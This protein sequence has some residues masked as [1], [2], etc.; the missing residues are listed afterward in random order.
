MASSANPK[1]SGKAA[2]PTATPTTTNN[3]RLDE[4]EQTIDQQEAQLEAQQE[5]IRIQGAEVERQALLLEQMTVAVQQLQAQANTPASST[6]H[7]TTNERPRTSTKVLPPRRFD[8]T[9]AKLEGFLT[10]MNIYLRFNHTAFPN[11]TDKILAV[12]MQMEGDAGDWMEPMVKDYLD[13]AED[14][15]DCKESTQIVFA[16]YSSF[17]TEIRKIFGE[18]DPSRTAERRLRGLRQAKSAAT[19]TTE[20]KQIQNRIEWDNDA[21]NSCYY[22]GLKDRVKDEISRGERPELLEDM[23]ALALRIDNRQFEREMEKKRQTPF[24]PFEHRRKAQTGHRRHQERGE[25]MDL[26]RIEQARPSYAPKPNTRRVGK[27]GKPARTYGISPEERQKRYDSKSCLIC[28]K[29]GHFARECKEKSKPENPGKRVAVIQSNREITGDEAERRLAQQLCWKCNSNGH[30]GATC[31]LQHWE[32]DINAPAPR[33]HAIIMAIAATQHEISD[34]QDAVRFLQEV[35]QGRKLPSAT[36]RRET[37]GRTVILRQ[38]DDA[39][40][41]Y[42]ENLPLPTLWI[43]AKNINFSL[44]HEQCWI[45]TSELHV[46]NDCMY[47]DHPVKTH[48]KGKGK[49]RE[50]AVQAQGPHHKLQTAEDTGQG[51]EE[52]ETDPEVIPDSESEADSNTTFQLTPAE[53]QADEES[54][55]TV[56]ENKE[57][58][59]NSKLLGGGWLFRHNS[60]PWKDCTLTSS[61]R[62]HAYAR[63]T[64]ARNEQDEDHPLVSQEECEV[65]FCGNHEEQRRGRKKE[66][67]FTVSINKPTSANAHANTHWTWCHD[68]ACAI[69]RGAKEGAGF[70]PKKPRK[71]GR[72]EKTTMPTHYTQSWT[73]C[74]DDSCEIHAEYKDEAQHWPSQG[75]K[76]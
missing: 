62:C 46:A 12:G 69:H 72:K 2:T 8:G 16:S 45:C 48:G 31:I 7:A 36:E 59:Y 1:G 57:T 60:K 26:D 50:R 29:E 44:D 17:T 56:Q 32:I 71:T 66:T 52:P 39:S 70:W 58:P 24:S 41:P 43:H 49:A 64:T 3:Q 74:Y 11:E 10:G 47:Q 22:E 65:P 68:D 40:N 75:R 4:A 13:N 53:T 67:P 21:L 55:G 35:E 30:E 37:R 42:R 76:N 63:A 34:T 61:C 9:P 28:G 25:P 73:Q 51:S 20:F 18:I 6:Q 33:K 5:T 23:I 14:L 27:Q 19:Y 54:E 38:S 15:S